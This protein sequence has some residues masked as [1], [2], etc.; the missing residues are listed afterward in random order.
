LIR[1]L[2]FAN[3]KL[4][5][6]LFVHSSMKSHNGMRPQD[7]VILLKIIAL[8]KQSWQNK[9]LAWHL[10]ISASEISESLH[11][12]HIAGLIDFNKKKVFRQ[13]LMEFLEYGLH[14][15]FP[16]IPGAIT[17]GIPTA[18]SHPYMQE[19]FQSDELYVWPEFDGSAK[20]QEILPLYK[21]SIK[22]VR[23]DKLFYKL[24]ALTDVIRVGR[25]RELKVA[26]RELKN[27]ILHEL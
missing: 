6:T 15:V 2:Q 10:H 4:F 9:D 14:Y 7:I 18:H 11:R 24:L 20:G 22:N 13:S 25:T 5:R 23:E 17:T 1:D 16:V 19:H 8:D 3:C 21:E 27:I 12:S 26:I